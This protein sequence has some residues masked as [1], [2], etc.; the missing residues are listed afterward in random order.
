M[1]E[2]EEKNGDG[3]QILRENMEE[4]VIFRPMKETDTA[5]AAEIEA[6]SSQEPWPQKAF[7][8]AL[9]NENAFYLVAEQG[10]SVVG[11]CGFWQSFE[12]ADICNVVVAQSCRRQ[13]IAERM[14]TALMKA[15]KIRGIQYFTLEVRCGNMPAV[16]LYEK[17]GFAAEGVRK[18]FYQNPKEDALI[19]WKR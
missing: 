10:G 11:C 2:A 9:C 1:M 13:G 17:L 19:M 15:G 5:A 3:I 16:R 6:A 12:D 7:A 14:L 4:A 8:D 18:G